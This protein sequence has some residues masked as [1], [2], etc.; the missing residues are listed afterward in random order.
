LLQLFDVT[1]AAFGEILS[2]AEVEGVPKDLTEAVTWYRK[3]EE[4]GHEEAIEALHQ[5]NIK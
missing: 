1:T 5:L 3:A 4:Q 2:C